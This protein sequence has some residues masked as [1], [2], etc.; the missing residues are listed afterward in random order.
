MLRNYSEDLGPYC[1]IL[2]FSEDQQFFQKSQGIDFLYQQIL[3]F[4]FIDRESIIWDRGCTFE[5]NYQPGR[6][7]GRISPGYLDVYTETKL[8]AN[9]FFL[10]LRF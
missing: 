2:F 3:T 7:P 5:K 8:Q 1:L 4:S 6:P 10:I 9:C